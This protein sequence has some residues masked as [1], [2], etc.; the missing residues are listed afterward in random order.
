MA[1]YSRIGPSS[2]SSAMPSG[3]FVVAPQEEKVVCKF[4][5]HGLIGWTLKTCFGINGL[6][7]PLAWIIMD[8]SALFLG[9]SDMLGPIA[10]FLFEFRTAARTFAD[11]AFS[12]P[13]LLNPASERTRHILCTT[14]SDTL[15]LCTIRRK[16]CFVHFKAKSLKTNS[17]AK[18]L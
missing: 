17:C 11:A 3:T 13:S 18:Y 12:V 5:L 8:S 7:K 9:Y 6:Q 2:A 14:S 4:H 15:Q 16:S 10:M 1:I